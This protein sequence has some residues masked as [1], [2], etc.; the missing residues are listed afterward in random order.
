MILEYR[1]EEFLIENL[2]LIDKDLTLLYN[3]KRFIGK[4][5]PDICCKDSKGNVIII[6]VKIYA[7][8][9]TTEQ[10]KK[11]IKIFLEEGYKRKQIIGHIACLNYNP[12]LKEECKR[13][14]IILDVIKDK[15]IL[16]LEKRYNNLPEPHKLVLE[17]FIFAKHYLPPICIM[18]KINN[19]EEKVKQI[20]KEL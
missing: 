20:I 17:K 1:L 15:R 16:N 18:S 3:Q 19:S 12:K 13:E 5:K 8:L 11:Y 4:G 2:D 7:P 9:Y 10:V 14:K 6:E